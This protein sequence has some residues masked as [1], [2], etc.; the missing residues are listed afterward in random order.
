M[1]PGN[2]TGAGIV[3]ICFL[4]NLGD[5]RIAHGSDLV[6]KGVGQGCTHLLSHFGGTLG[7]GL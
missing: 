2:D 5:L 1:A 4:Y 3:V 6:N 7:D